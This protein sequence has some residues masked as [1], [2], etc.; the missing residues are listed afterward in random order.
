MRSTEGVGWGSLHPDTV[1]ETDTDE[2]GSPGADIFRTGDST[3]DLS[4]VTENTASDTDGPDQST[5][6]ESDEAN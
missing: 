5:E 1:D 6:E 2:S 4:D 3:T